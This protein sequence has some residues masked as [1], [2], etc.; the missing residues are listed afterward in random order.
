MRTT[1]EKEH[2]WSEE[3]SQT[4]AQLQLAREKA[5]QL[6]RDGR[7]KSK[8]IEELKLK[9]ASAQRLQHFHE[10]EVSQWCFS[11]SLSLSLSL[12]PQVVTGQDHCRYISFFLALL[13]SFLTN[14]LTN[15]T[16]GCSLAIVYTEQVALFNK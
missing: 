4:A 10:Q 14:Q 11:L 9:L 2:H 13:I 1:G 15:H 16:K 3:L 5:E 8:T 12:P 6:E 7:E